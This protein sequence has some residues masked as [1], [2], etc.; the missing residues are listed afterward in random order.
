MVGSG[1]VILLALGSVFTTWSFF[2]NTVDRAELEQ[3]REENSQLQATNASFETNIQELQQQLTEYEERTRRLAIVAGLEAI[4]SDAEIGI[5][6]ETLGL[7]TRPI[8]SEIDLVDSRTRAIDATLD[9]VA[10]RL[11]ERLYWIS[12]TPAIAPAKGI[13]TSGFGYRSDPMTRRRQ[14]HGALDIAASPYGPVKAP[15]DGIV[16]K[17]GQTGGGMGNAVYISHGLGVTTR[18]AHLARVKVEAGQSVQR[19]DM[20][21][22]VGN[23]GRATGYHLHYEVR[24][25]DKPVNPLGYI[26]DGNSNNS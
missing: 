7:E 16:I 5:G 26:L 8:G 23:T 3:I 11:D 22:T 24:V 20:V 14:F 25:D 19:G 21:G 1:L 15:A 9:A 2:T 13:I 18:Y 4:T 6:G 10:Q 17:A 12:S